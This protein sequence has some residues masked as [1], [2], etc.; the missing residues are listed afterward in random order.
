MIVGGGDERTVGSGVAVRGAETGRRT[1]GCEDGGGVI[2]E[3]ESATIME[4]VG[5]FPRGISSFEGM[6]APIGCG[7][8]GFSAGVAT[9][10]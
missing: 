3:A 10:S 4:V 6:S 2:D 9:S 8:E 5:E 7:V 1:G